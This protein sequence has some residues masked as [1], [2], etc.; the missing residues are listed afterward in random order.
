MTLPALLEDLAARF[1]P[2]EALVSPRRRVTYAELAA[3]S[4]AIARG[5]AARG[6]GKG[7]R[8]GLLMPN[9][10]EWIATA[11]GVWRCGGILVAL[12]TLARPREL[13]YALRHH[14]LANEDSW[15]RPCIRTDAAAAYATAL[16]AAR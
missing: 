15:A 8:V 1:G 11:F 7:T 16:A 12:N 6:V 2:R 5:L 4:I 10:P 3:D 9:W 14:N 13:A